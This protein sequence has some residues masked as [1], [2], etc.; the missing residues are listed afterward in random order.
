M[1]RVG[2][3]DIGKINVPQPVTNI[4]SSPLLNEKGVDLNMSPLLDGSTPLAKHYEEVS[5]MVANPISLW[6]Q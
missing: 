3:A 6:S 1:M 4:V 5:R 2:L